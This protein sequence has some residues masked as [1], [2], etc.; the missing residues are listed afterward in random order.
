MQKVQNYN[1]ILIND[2]SFSLKI[3]TLKS[4]YKKLQG[5]NCKLPIILGHSAH[6]PTV[7][8]KIKPSSLRFSFPIIAISFF[9][10]VAEIS[11]RSR[12]AKRSTPSP[13]S[14]ITAV[15]KTAGSSSTARFSSLLVTHYSSPNYAQSSLLKS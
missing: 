15:P 12:W 4:Q 11:C 8:R 14:Q 13:T 2:T 7:P 10:L 1:F 6:L 5:Y 9:F 3:P